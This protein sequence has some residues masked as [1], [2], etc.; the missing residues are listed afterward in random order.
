MI[1]DLTI[2]QGLADKD[3]QLDPE[4]VG[5]LPRMTASN[6]RAWAW[7]T[8]SF[9]QNTPV[10]QEARDI[11]FGL[12]ADTLTGPVRNYVEQGVKRASYVRR[13]GT[14]GHRLQKI[15]D[16]AEREGATEDQMYDARKYIDAMLGTHGWRTHQSIHKYVNKF[17][18]VIGKDP[19]P[20]PTPG[21]PISRRMMK[22]QQWV[23]TYQNIRLLDFA[24]LTSLMDPVGIYARTGDIRM[25][26]NAWRD[27]VKAMAKGVKKDPDMLVSIG[28]MTGV[29][30][31][32][33]MAEALQW[34][35]A[36][37][38]MTGKARRVNDLFFKWNG[39]SGWT[40]TTRL[41]AVSA[42]QQFMK[43][44]IG[45]FKELSAPGEALR[46]KEHEGTELTPEEQ[47][48]LDMYEQSERYLNELGLRPADLERDLF[49][50]DGNLR[51][52]SSDQLGE[53]ETALREKRIKA[54]QA[55][56]KKQTE[57]VQA[58]REEHA[59]LKEQLA[60]EQR[61]RTALIRFTN[62]AILRPNAAQR[63]IWASD[64][65]FAV[66]FHLKQF[67]WS[68]HSRILGRMG[69]EAM[70]GNAA[71]VIYSAVMFAA[72]MAASDELRDE[73][74]YGEEGN[75]N[76]ASWGFTDYLW[77]A[78]QRAG[79]TGT[80]QAMLDS[81]EDMTYGGWGFESFIGPT[82]TQA[83]R[84]TKAPFR[85]TDYLWKQVNSA[86][87]LN[88]TRQVAG[89]TLPLEDN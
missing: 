37:N 25:S 59:A 71:P 5:H 64:P 58:L 19:L 4:H 12:Q 28:E 55:S 87:P 66:V 78:I 15:L 52:M 16:Q 79:L 53:A 84:W 1:R 41:M 65:H 24:V 17:R 31:S 30:E 46:A 76:K 10:T 61:V 83:L 42:G 69:H 86:G 45:R 9:D 63:P 27:G 75:P 34:N 81:R 82:F 60:S 23:M 50:A 48:T 6:T 74:K 56:K 54:K 29:I 77:S 68:F 85:D 2:E 44:H 26:W 14:N 13:F 20:E 70:Q 18:E 57:R 73:L 8:E 80:Y 36:G 7:I 72:V 49:D 11:W 89:W 51:L 40:K 32:N 67:I 38:F 39:L 21:K 33:V 22:A 43:F 3:P 47:N 35:Y 88:N 62:E